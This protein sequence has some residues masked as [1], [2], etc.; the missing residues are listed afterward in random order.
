MPSIFDLLDAVAALWA[1]LPNGF[2]GEGPGL[3][4]AV[5]GLGGWLRWMVVGVRRA[6]DD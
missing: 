5:L 6:L 1:D 4:L 3:A 2:D